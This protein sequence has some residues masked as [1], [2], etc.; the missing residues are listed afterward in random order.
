[1][2]QAPKGNG[3]GQ[4]NIDP[5]E[6]RRLESEFRALQ[7]RADGRDIT[8]KHTDGYVMDNVMLRSAEL[9]AYFARELE[10]MWRKARKI[11]GLS[12][13]QQRDIVRRMASAKLIRG[14]KDVHGTWDLKA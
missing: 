10:K 2:S 4:F 14:S 12:P 1:M 6:W 13:D 9:A 5:A 8:A 7:K 3:Q 11:K